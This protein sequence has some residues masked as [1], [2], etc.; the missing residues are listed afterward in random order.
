[1]PPKKQPAS[2]SSKVAVDKV[3]YTHELLHCKVIQTI[4]NYQQTFGMKNVRHV[5]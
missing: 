3:R 2:S 5:E 1:M 4:R